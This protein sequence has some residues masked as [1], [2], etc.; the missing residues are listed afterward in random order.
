MRFP[1]LILCFAAAA[2]IASAK[3]ADICLTASHIDHTVTASDREILYYMRDGKIWKNT[4]KRE[5]PGLR[6]E[7]AFRTDIAGGEVCSN[8]QM[9][10]VVHRETP[11]FL[12]AFTPY[13][14]PP[15]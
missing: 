5:C 13:T 4:L 1:A 8:R 9:I 2:T 12:G 6:F 7:H 3:D 11:C 15:G 14:P 10:Q